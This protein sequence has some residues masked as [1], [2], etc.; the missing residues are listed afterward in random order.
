[1]EENGHSTISTKAVDDWLPITGDRHAKWWYS[2]FHNVTAMVGAGVLSLPYAMVYLT[3]LVTK[4][5]LCICNPTL[6]KVVVSFFESF[7]CLILK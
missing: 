4:K 5:N 2:A 1:M 7:S 3:W 6:P